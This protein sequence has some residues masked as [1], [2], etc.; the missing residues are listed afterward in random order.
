MS[1]TEL[2]LPPGPAVFTGGGTGGH[3]YPAK[4][5]ID[6]LLTDGADRRVYWIGS[7]RGMEKGI[8][9]KW[10]IPYYGISSG[11]LRRYFDLQNFTDLFRI[12][13]G[14][15]Q[16]RRI[17]RRDRPLF[18]FSKGGFV[19][20]PPVLAAKSLGI[21]VYT[22]ESDVTPGLATRINSRFVTKIFLP[23]EES[24]KY[25]AP[26]FRSRCLVSGNPVRKEFF[27]G[28]PGKG[29]EF[30][31][32]PEGLPVL[33]VMGGSLG[34]E[35]INRL[36]EDNLQELTR[37]CFVIHQ[38]GTANYIP[39][40]HENYF[41][42]PYFNEEISH[43]IACADGALS[44]AGAAAV[45]ELAA[46]RTPMLLLPLI[47]GSRGDQVH[48]ARIFEEAGAARVLDENTLKN[49]FFLLAVK[50]LLKGPGKDWESINGA[51]KMGQ[52]RDIILK[53][54]GE[55]LKQ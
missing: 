8:V 32:A 34:A 1:T 40:D 42:A 35:R 19:S 10:D 38:T 46:G 21:P 39:L 51:L 41:R 55:D 47:K 24:L 7:S 37:F 48:N 23:Y 31:K 29:R 33:L 3:V 4:P 18:L 9:E 54:I 27:S 14:F 43:L 52:A 20:V 28:N 2:F 6:S 13:A 11:K 26:A 17:L 15:F 49:E 50:E 36:V 25:M 22:H 12:M 30:V 45:W 44:R 5:L 53:S 16:A